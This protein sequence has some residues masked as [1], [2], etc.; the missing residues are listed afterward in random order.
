MGPFMVEIVFCRVTRRGRKKKSGMNKLAREN[1]RNDGPMQSFIPQDDMIKVTLDLSGK[2][3]RAKKKSFN[4]AVI[5]TAVVCIFQIIRMGQANFLCTCP[6][7]T[8]PFHLYRLII[9]LSINEPTVCA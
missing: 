9:L 3:T 4:Q 6:E 7:T 5:L 2:G 1:M 8:S